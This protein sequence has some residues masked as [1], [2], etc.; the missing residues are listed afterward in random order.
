MIAEESKSAEFFSRARLR[1]GA[2][3]KIC[4]TVCG[5]NRRCAICQYAASSKGGGDIG[6]GVPLP[7]FSSLFA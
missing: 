3:E 1:G 6:R 4:G 2:V 7:F 5:V